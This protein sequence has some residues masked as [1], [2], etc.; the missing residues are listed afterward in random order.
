MGLNFYL[1]I[2]KTRYHL[3]KSSGGWL[4]TWNLITIL[5]AIMTHHRDLGISLRLQQQIRD[6]LLFFKIGPSKLTADDAANLY[7]KNYAYPNRD[8]L[9]E[10]VKTYPW[11]LK[12]ET[13]MV[14]PNIPFCSVNTMS[15]GVYVNIRIPFLSDSQIFEWIDQLLDMNEENY[16]ED[17]YGQI[18]SLDEF[19][20]YTQPQKEGPNW[21]FISYVRDTKHDV[22]AGVHPEYLVGDMR[23]MPYADFD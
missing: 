14:I 5:G 19:L 3:G 13:K 17:E 18:Y 8:R 6:L 21:D 10:L 15:S 22:N 16:I 12:A 9:H 20:K 7:I 2:A 23:C 1:N 4:F 11:L